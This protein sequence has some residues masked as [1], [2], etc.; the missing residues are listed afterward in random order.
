LPKRI[1]SFGWSITCS[2]SSWLRVE[3]KEFAP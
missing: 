1:S 3:M 2:N